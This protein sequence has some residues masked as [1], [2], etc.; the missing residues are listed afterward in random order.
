FEHGLDLGRAA[1]LT[2]LAAES[3]LDPALVEAQLADTAL[4]DAVA[5]EERAAAEL[6]ISGVPF[7]VL[8]GRWAISGAQETSVF[9]AALDRVAAVL[10]PGEHRPP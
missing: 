2:S 4:G 5:A 7:T 1:V 8:A 6:G 9:V 10:A 3:G